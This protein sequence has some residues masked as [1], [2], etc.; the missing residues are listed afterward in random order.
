[1]PRQSRFR[2]RTGRS[3][4]EYSANT[5]PTVLIYPTSA[6]EFVRAEPERS[7][8]ISTERD[9]YDDYARMFPNLRAIRHHGQ[10][11]LLRV[12]NK[13]S[14]WNYDHPLDVVDMLHT[15]SLV[16]DNDLKPDSK[17]ASLDTLILRDGTAVLSEMVYADL[18][19]YRRE[20]PNAVWLTYAL[21]HF[22]GIENLV[23]HLRLKDES[24][25]QVAE[26]EKTPLR[27]LRKEEWPALKT[28]EFRYA[29]PY[30]YGNR[31]ICMLVSLVILMC[32]S[33]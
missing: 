15:S 25:A 14:D 18:T 23:M 17:P 33:S 19:P 24:S 22:V 5:C 12:L 32:H 2:R 26:K 7:F 21:R 8:E 16:G 9:D 28:V 4:G 20:K 3:F 30:A 13:P 31:D 1:M 6:I 27:I 11:K 10:I 29:M